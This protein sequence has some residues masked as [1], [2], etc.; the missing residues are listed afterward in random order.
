MSPVLEPRVDGCGL[1][2]DPISV[3]LQQ[4]KMKLWAISDSRDFALGRLSTC[5]LTKHC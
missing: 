5:A 1:Q 3:M 4:A 2:M